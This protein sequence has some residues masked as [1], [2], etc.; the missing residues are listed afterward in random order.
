MIKFAEVSE[1]SK[2]TSDK[3][4]SFL[5]DL[6]PFVS[7]KEVCMLRQVCS[8]WKQK[9]DTVVCKKILY[10]GTNSI[11]RINSIS[12]P[13]S[14]TPYQFLQSLYSQPVKTVTPQLE[15]TG[16]SSHDFNQHPYNMYIEDIQNNHNEYFGHSGFW[17]SQGSEKQTQDKEFVSF[18]LPNNEIL[19]PDRLTLNFYRETSFDPPNDLFPSSSITITLSLSPDFVEDKRLTFS[20]TYPAEKTNLKQSFQ[21]EGFLCKYIKITFNDKLGLQTQD[22]KYYVCVERLSLSGR[23][24]TPST[25]ATLF[26]ALDPSLAPNLDLSTHLSSLQS[27]LSSLPKEQ[28]SQFIINNQLL[29]YSIDDGMV[30]DMEVPM[31][32]RQGSLSPLG[33]RIALWRYSQGGFKDYVADLAA[34]KRYLN[35]HK[36]VLDGFREFVLSGS[37]NTLLECTYSLVTKDI[38]DITTQNNLKILQAHEE[39]EA[40]ES[41]YTSQKGI[42]MRAHGVLQLFTDLISYLA[43]IDRR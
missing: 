28:R 19:F 41:I 37:L 21:L 5:A 1:K 9:V 6:A 14:A 15:L 8:T 20:K 27:Q 25:S 31:V 33:V 13:P 29:L 43:H 39:V 17:S 7:M 42:F 36:A 23:I 24:L 16:H 30:A 40:W 18:A 3:M 34:G 2:N 4:S 26:A 35:R 10:N 38:F 32:E 22:M 12:I 11:L